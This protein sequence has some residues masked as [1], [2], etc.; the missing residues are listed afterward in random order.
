MD[1][2][3][4]QSVMIILGPVLLAA[5]LAWAM[6]HNRTSRRQ[7]AETEQAT[8]RLYEEQDRIDNG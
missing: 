2:S 5:A 3:S 1:S 4:L 7:K 6:L 8:K